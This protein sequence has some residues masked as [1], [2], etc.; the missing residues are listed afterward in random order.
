[1]AGQRG[2][3]DTFSDSGAHIR[4]VSDQ[5]VNVSPKLVPLLKRIGM[6]GRAGDNPKRE[7]EEDVGIA[8][9]DTISTTTTMANTSVTALHLSGDNAFNF[10]IGDLLLIQDEQ[11]RVTA[12]AGDG[13]LTVSRGWGSTTAATHDSTVAITKIGT[14]LPE[15]TDT[16]LVGSVD[17]TFP[18]NY[19]T[20]FNKAYQV[21]KRQQATSIYGVSD[22]MDYQA[23][24]TLE[25]LMLLCE[26]NIFYGKRVQGS[27][28][29]ASNF[30][31]LDVFITD[32]T[33]TGSEALTEKKIMDLL[34]LCWDDVGHENL[35]T[36]IV[37]NAWQKRKISDIYRPMAR[38]DRGSTKGGVVTDR[39]E[40]DLG[41]LEVMLDHNTPT[42]R[43][44][45]LNP[46]FI[47]IGPY[48]DST[49]YT[50]ALPADGAYQ[51]EHV[52]G[53][54]SFQVKADKAHGSMT[55]LSTS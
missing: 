38:M 35:P 23:A 15:N 53:D 6:S 16:P 10:S 45:L 46:S 14:A 3:R 1:M 21:S 22:D 32:N 17:L 48:K 34:Q 49:F 43:L 37:V 47:E 30:G 55:N 2:A 12:L 42:D 11:L 50:A 4:D 36:L 7:W 13:Q 20:I 18:Y 24:K 19:Y 28:T 33:D 51:K 40:T 52:Y 5:I 39:I 41:P 31:G 26:K 25:H 27:A 8:L 9:T 44:F 54:Y 29:A